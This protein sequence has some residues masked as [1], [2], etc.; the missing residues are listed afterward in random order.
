[1][2]LIC[3]VNRSGTSVVAQIIHHLGLDLGSR[4]GLFAFPSAENPRGFFEHM[5]LSMVNR[6]LLNLS[7]Q[8]PGDVKKEELEVLK[9]QARE[10]I[11]DEGIQAFKDPRSTILTH[12]WNDVI[13]GI[14]AIVKVWRS[15][16]EVAASMAKAESIPISSA[17]QIA[18]KYEDTFWRDVSGLGIPIYVISHR[19]LITEPVFA[20]TK[21][22]NFLEAQNLPVN[23][24][25]DPHKLA[26]LVD[27]SLHRM[28]LVDAGP[29]WFKI[30]SSGTVTEDQM[31]EE[32]KSRG[33]A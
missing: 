17:V 27:P 6:R 29:R 26:E 20:I 7:N 1:M 12:F 23:H 10:I 21:L 14:P 33:M 4:T 8:F 19:E 9:R 3:G 22:K 18:N 25:K 28:K 5:K 2:L 24:Q 15:H 16:D 13:R 11:A 32:L 30:T 31:R